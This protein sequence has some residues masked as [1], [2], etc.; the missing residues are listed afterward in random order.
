MKSLVRTLGG[1]L[2]FVTFVSGASVQDE[3]ESPRLILVLSIDQMRFDYLTR[4]DDLYTGGLRTLLD[5]GAIMTDAKYRH[6]ATE[7]GPGHATLISGRHPSSSGI[8]ANDWWDRLLHKVV[9]VVD[10]PFQRPLGGAGRS[11]SPVNF[12][13]FTIGDSLKQNSPQSK[14][15]GV[16]TKDRSAIL[17]AG[18]LGDA[19]YWFERAEGNFITSTYYMD[20]VPGW[21]ERWNQR[22]V[23][24][25]YAGTAWTR[26]V[27]DESLYE[28]Y[29]G[30]DAVVGEWTAQDTV[31]PHR[32]PG[33]PPEPVYFSYVR[34]S[35]FADEM[36]L[37]VAL[38]AV[39]AHDI[40]EDE[41]TDLLALGFSGV[42][43]VGH[44]FGPDSQE[45]MDQ[46]LRLDRILGELFDEIDLRNGLD[47]TLVVLTADHGVL[48]LVETLKAQG[49][50]AG[51]G[52]PESQRAAVE[53]ALREEYPGADGL[54][55]YFQDRDIYLNQE[56]IRNRGLDRGAV[57][58]TI[59]EALQST[60]LVAAVYTREQLVG[61]EPVTD[62]YIDLFRNSFLSNRS[63][64]LIVRHN[65]NVYID[66]DPGGTGH[67]TPY[68]Y[69]R[70][71]PI[72]F[73]GNGIEPGWYSEAC[74][75]EDIAPT[76][77]LILGL[78]YPREPDSRLLLEI[79]K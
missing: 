39:G 58:E 43:L 12:S 44:E 10:D 49:I 3:A 25:S 32:F 26:L 60:G 76:L 54:I 42:D 56:L 20:E 14:V 33:N 78:E 57:E 37:S 38:E 35:P 69:D 64:D 11:A 31:F 13:G 48:P 36:M 40:G 53:R 75:P 66:R 79:L 18:R 23:A 51:R 70:H 41:F 1:L 17:M 7:T 24:D 22:R 16:S 45:L 55:A 59:I 29:A 5:R 47:R 74:G 68:D 72:V 21:L 62:P 28:E 77:A 63:P 8:I 19:A 73:M 61:N 50:D 15:V 67:G 27:D 6:A 2:L 30:E 65:E 4:F 71:V 9:N 34:R 46:M 52:T